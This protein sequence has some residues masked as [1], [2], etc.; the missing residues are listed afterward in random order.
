MELSEN[1]LRDFIEHPIWKAFHDEMLEMRKI[2]LESMVTEVS[3][4]K[5]RMH[6]G[7]AEVLADLV[8]WPEMQLSIFDK[9]KKVDKNG[10]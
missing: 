7:R 5:V 6:Q 1:Q 3:V 8:S 10:E 4:D 9:S 2:V